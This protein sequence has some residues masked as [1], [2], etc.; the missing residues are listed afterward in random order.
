MT[1][2]KSDE[3]G[4]EIEFPNLDSTS[5]TECDRSEL[6]LEAATSEVAASDL[7]SY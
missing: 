7:I 4:E 6:P 1:S 2:S 5:I 3:F